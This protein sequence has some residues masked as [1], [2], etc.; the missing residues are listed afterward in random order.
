MK[1]MTGYGRGT[2]ENDG[3]RV[4]VE[5]S[6]LNRKQLDVALTLP[7]EWLAMEN[8]V[9]KILA[10]VAT[11][12]RV[13]VRVTA[14]RVSGSDRKVV[15]D[16]ALLAD[17]K[18][19]LRDLL[20]EEP[21]LTVPDLL[22]LPG[23]LDFRESEVD[24][25]GIQNLLEG[26]LAQSMEAWDMMRLVEGRHL[27]SDIET[28]LDSVE[29]AVTAMDDRAP[30]VVAAQ[31][32]QLRA[33]LEQSGI[34]LD[35]DDERIT[36]EL[37]LFADRCD[38]SEERVRLRSH[39]AQFRLLLEAVEPPGRTMD[40]LVQEMNREVNTIG[41]KAADTLMARQVV[42]AKTELEKIREQAQNIE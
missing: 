15:A 30:D 4:H 20:G 17:Y 16:L 23:V 1:S 18:E 12:G 5:I 34:E 32:E 36:R 27:R 42:A 13:Q 26:A 29:S 19:K 31:R 11:R 8:R 10:E 9:R 21:V 2:A 37:A 39:L 25:E 38:T 7:R 14:E 41:S 24:P 6:S 28:R 3:L 33:R 35:L 40:F 22:R